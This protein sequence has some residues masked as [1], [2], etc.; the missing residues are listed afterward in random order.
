MLLS[1]AGAVANSVNLNAYLAVVG[2][3]NGDLT[4]LLTIFVGDVFG[5]A[6]VL[7]LLATVLSLAAQRLQI[8]YLNW[9][10]NNAPAPVLCF[11]HDFCIIR[12]TCLHSNFLVGPI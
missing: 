6:I 8:L 9:T 2:R 11:E 10:K 3:L 7:F 5:T 1:I 4:Q 12:V